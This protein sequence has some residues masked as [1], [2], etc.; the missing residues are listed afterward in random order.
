MN[1][2]E[3][4][5][6]HALGTLPDSIAARRELLDAA[7]RACPKNSPLRQHAALLVRTLDAHERAQQ[8]FCF[9]GEPKHN[10]GKA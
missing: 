7:R 3:K 10:G 5:V 8:E 9:A 6:K 4:I 1:A 2:I